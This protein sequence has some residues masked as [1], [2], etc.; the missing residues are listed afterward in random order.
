MSDHQG[1]DAASQQSVYVIHGEMSG[2]AIEAS[3]RSLLRARSRPIARHRLTVLDTFDG[4]VRR[5]GAR[6]NRTGQADAS[7]MAWWPR[8]GDLPV[9]ARVSQPVSF[10]WDLP[11]GPLHEAVAPVVGVR[12]LIP[13]ADA[14]AQ[15][16]QFDILDD[17]HKT[18]ARLRIESGQVRPP[19]ARAAWR[20]LPTVLTLTGLRGYEDAYARLVP[21][22]QSRPGITP[23]P[24]GVERV[25]LEHAGVPEPRD[26]S[27]LEIDLAADVTASEGARRIH[28]ALAQV[29]A[30]NEPGLRDNID[31][32]FL[33][34]FRVAIRRTRALL[35][36][37]KY[38]FPPEI[39]DRYSTE[40]AWLGNLTGPP[41]DLDVLMLALRGRR[42]D[43]DTDAMGALVAF[44]ERAQAQEREA[45]I[46]ALDSERYRRLIA[47][48][49]VFLEQSAAS[50]AAHAHRLLVDVVAA[51]A[52]KLSKRIARSAGTID[53][54]TDPARLH[55]VRIDA[56]KLRYLIDV[57]PAF[58]DAE[59]LETVVTAL[60]KLQR[61][62]G[63]FND[64]QVQEARLLGCG[65][66]LGAAGGPAAAVLALGQLA[67]QSRQRREQ[68]RPQAIDQLAQFSARATRSACR[69]AFKRTSSQELTR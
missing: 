45:L 47:D 9:T 7:T 41:R 42:G 58:F 20:P 2:A 46:A 62:L 29:L 27:T 61:V 67:E 32:E 25:V 63:D 59:D 68:L 52:W 30:A 31:S 49:G 64:A 36:Q 66:A 38:V 65:R 37:L 21:I 18:V 17:R 39:V 15:G 4:R 55:E 34:D 10:A 23:C 11:D 5:A 14:E 3:L 19:A 53:D 13:Q 24:D 1:R 50:A 48:W 35:R 56:K 60:K 8:S 22:V 57:T 54:R 44:L 40:F 16:T 6:L 28:R 43:I 26:V 33:H 69:R 51:R 12:R